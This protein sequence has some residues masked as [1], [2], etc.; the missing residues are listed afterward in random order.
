MLL[1]QKNITT[2]GAVWGDFSKKS[3]DFCDILHSLTEI[4]VFWLFPFGAKFSPFAQN[5]GEDAYLG[6]ARVYLVEVDDRILGEHIAVDVELEIIR[7][8]AK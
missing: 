5:K 7:R 6:L 4:N 2:T 8:G 3:G 1:R